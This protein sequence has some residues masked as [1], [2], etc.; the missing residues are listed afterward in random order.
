MQQPHPTLEQTGPPE[1]EEN[2][3]PSPLH[4]ARWCRTSSLQA[5]CRLAN[6]P[7]RPPL[8]WT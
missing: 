3:A 6:A 8:P 4:F 7:V 5:D 2:F 1:L